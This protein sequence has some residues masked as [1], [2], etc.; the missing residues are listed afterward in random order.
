MRLFR[1]LPALAALAIVLPVHAQTVPNAGTAN[2]LMSHLPDA[3]NVLAKPLKT[4]ERNPFGFS[5]SLSA[6]DP[7][8]DVLTNGGTQSNVHAAWADI[9]GVTWQKEDTDQQW[10]ATATFGA[11]VSDKPEAQFQVTFYADADGK[12]DNNAPAEGVRGEMDK[13]WSVK[14]SDQYGWGV[15]YRWYNPAPDFWAMDK[16]TTGKPL[17]QGN[18]VTMHIP[19]AE[20]PASWSPRWRVIA[21]VSGSSDV[22]VDVAPGIG[23][24]AEK[25]KKEI[26][27]SSLP[28]WPLTA[29]AVVILGLL[30]WY[31]GKK[32]GF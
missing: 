15:D 14:Y 2:Y 5:T 25:G 30:G 19:Y 7:A 3:A 29:G 6:E 21:A 17:V 1:L 11:P 28:V 16:K 4:E 12:A 22:Q 20:L 8:G 18:T 27:S 10:R 32:K 9:T 31:V 26:G 13:E 24:P 23:F